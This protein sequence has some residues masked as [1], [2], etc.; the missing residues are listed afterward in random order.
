[1]SEG[2]RA[3]RPV[4]S[5][6]TPCPPTH[7]PLPTAWPALFAFGVTLFAWGL[8][9]SFVVSLIGGA[10]LFYSL[11]HWIGEIAHDAK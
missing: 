4:P 6:W 7:A 3:A 8:V 10:L 9:S 1:V 5:G 11:F 2:R